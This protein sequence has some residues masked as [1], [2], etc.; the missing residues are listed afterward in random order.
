MI[1]YTQQ[2]VCGLLGVMSL[3]ACFSEWQLWVHEEDEDEYRRSYFQ[4]IGYVYDNNYRH[5]SAVC[6]TVF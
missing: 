4:I 3:A 2:G 6:T 5:R 1:L